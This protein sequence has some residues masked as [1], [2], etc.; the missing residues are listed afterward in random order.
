[1]ATF[2]SAPHIVAPVTLALGPLL[3][4]AITKWRRPEARLLLALA[5]IPHTI[6]MYETVP[7]FL[8]VRT[9]PEAWFLR[10]ATATADVVQRSTAG[11]SASTFTEYTLAG[12]QLIVWFAYLPCLVMIL[13][14]PN[15]APEDRFPAHRASADTIWA[16]R[17]RAASVVAMREGHDRVYPSEAHLRVASIPILP[18]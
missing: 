8:I 9:W 4:L 15:E 10:A 5:C 17:R 3:L 12:A 13:R 6:H 16:A 14:R 11:Y 18:P 2:S 7:L 1:M